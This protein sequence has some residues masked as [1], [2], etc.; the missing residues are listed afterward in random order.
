MEQRDARGGTLI[1]GGC[2]RLSQTEWFPKRSSPP[3]GLLTT[4]APPTQTSPV[5]RTSEL[6]NRPPVEI[7]PLARMSP[8]T[9]SLTPGAAVPTPTLPSSCTRMSPVPESFWT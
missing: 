6:G 1:L 4:G 2:E 5:L 3:D 9:S 8:A 7:P